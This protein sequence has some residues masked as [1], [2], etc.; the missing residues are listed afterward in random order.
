MC[1]ELRG[2]WG[3]LQLHLHCSY[4]RSSP[5]SLRLLNVVRRPPS[6]WRPS[7]DIP[8]ATSTAPPPPHDILNIYTTVMSTTPRMWNC[9]LGLGWSTCLMF[10]S[11]FR[12]LYDV[13]GI[14]SG[15]RRKAFLVGF[16]W[17][18]A[19]RS[20]EREITSTPT[21]GDTNRQSPRTSLPVLG[22]MNFD[23][24]SEKWISFFSLPDAFIV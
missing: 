22:W 14:N 9:R 2:G 17:D 6:H 7:V 11:S 21:S 4:S 8:P 19:S 18:L 3:A 23:Q 1:L 10:C 12:G 5:W 15:T 13:K 24:Y 16:Q 20:R